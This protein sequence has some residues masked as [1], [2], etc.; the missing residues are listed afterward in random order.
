MVYSSYVSVFIMSDILKRTDLSPY[1]I[2][3]YS[4]ADNEFFFFF[5]LLKAKDYDKGTFILQWLI[6]VLAVAICKLTG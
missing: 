5:Y 3:W 4:I 1:E 6:L 2:P